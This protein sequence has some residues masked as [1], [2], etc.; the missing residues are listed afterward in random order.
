MWRTWAS[1]STGTPSSW[2]SPSSFSMATVSFPS[3][4]SYLPPTILP[5]LRSPHLPDH[6]PK[7]RGAQTEAEDRP[8]HHHDCCLCPHGH[9]TP[10]IWRTIHR[11]FID[12]QG[13][14][15]SIMFRMFPGS[16]RQSQQAWP[17]EAQHVH[18]AQVIQSLDKNV[19]IDFRNLISMFFSSQLGWSSGSFAF[20]LPMG[21][22]F[23][24]L[25]LPQVLTR[26]QSSHPSFSSGDQTI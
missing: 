21:S 14:L 20:R 19:S 8:R 16:F 26:D 22:R 2:P 12:S 6:P 5:L 3:T 9:W 1:P 23:R 17:T 4:Y 24:C 25:S 15:K 7:E 11:V 18:I 10:G 13:K